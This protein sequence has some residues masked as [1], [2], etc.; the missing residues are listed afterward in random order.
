MIKFQNIFI[1]P[2][3]NPLPLSIHSP[4]PGLELAVTVY[5]VSLE[6]PVLDISHEHRSPPLTVMLNCINKFSGKANLAKKTNNV[7]FP[8][9]F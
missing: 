9:V 6:L 8:T 1:T 2:K 4:F 3:R 5:V 7:L